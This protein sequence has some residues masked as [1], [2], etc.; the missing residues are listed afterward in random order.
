MKLGLI[1]DIHEHVEFLQ[2]ALDRFRSE[3]VDQIVVIGD[4]FA[5]GERIEDT[6]R[7]LSQANAIGVW[8]IT[9]LGFALIPTTW[10]V[11][12]TPQPCST[13]WLPCGLVWMSAAGSG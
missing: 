6:C 8:V 5:M 11:R 10:F 13:T 7:L 12:S 2:V 1:T 3:Q 4:V 9:I